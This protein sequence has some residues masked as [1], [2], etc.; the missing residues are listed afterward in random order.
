MAL[1]GPSWPLPTFIFSLISSLNNPAR[2]RLSP[3]EGKKKNQKTEKLLEMLV[4]A[5]NP[6]TEEVETRDQEFRVI[7]DYIASSRPA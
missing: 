5:Y 1:L 3:L 6:S 4:Q 2:W 7:L